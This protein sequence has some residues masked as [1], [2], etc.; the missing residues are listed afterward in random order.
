MYDVIVDPPLLGAFHLIEILD[1]FCAS[2]GAIKG[3]GA[4][5]TSTDNELDRL[6]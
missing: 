1:A 5:D 4:L 2:T 6:L 3:F